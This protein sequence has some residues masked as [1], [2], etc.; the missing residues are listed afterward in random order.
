LSGPRGPEFGVLV[1]EIQKETSVLNKH[2]VQE[3]ENEHA[4]SHDRH[5]HSEI[6]RRRETR[7]RLKTPSKKIDMPFQFGPGGYFFFTD[8]Q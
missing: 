1:L 5:T 8:F 2:R 4:D 7:E 6:A 3:K